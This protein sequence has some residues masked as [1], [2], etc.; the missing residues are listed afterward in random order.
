MEPVGE[1]VPQ[2]DG[3]EKELAKAGEAGR[4]TR[5][6]PRGNKTKGVAFAVLLLSS[7]LSELTS[8]HLAINRQSQK[9]E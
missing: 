2:A 1:V 8:Q 3:A 9:Q 4:V 7:Q 6:D 5:A